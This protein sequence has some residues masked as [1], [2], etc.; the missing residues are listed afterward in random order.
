MNCIHT[1][2]RMMFIG[3]LALLSCNNEPERQPIPVKDTLPAE[4]ANPYVAHDQSPLDMVYFPKNYPVLRMNGADSNLLVARVIYSRPQK[5]G[6]PIFGEGDKTLVHYGKEWRLGA[7][8]ATEIEFFKHV[9]SGNNKIS[10]GSYIMYA[11]PYADRWTIVFNK[12]LYTWGLHMDPAKDA[13]KVDVPVE[14][15]SPALE[16]FT[17]IIEA[18]PGGA[19]MIM[20]WDNVKTI[21]PFSFSK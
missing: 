11:I 6:R 10:K 7:N 12:N 4:A 17:I 9:A 13:F 19:K 18:M 14:Q 21:L 3:C 8:E 20:A 2:T 1:L 15:Q 5:N 16:D